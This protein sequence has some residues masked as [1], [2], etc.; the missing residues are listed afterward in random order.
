MATILTIANISPVQKT[1]LYGVGLAQEQMET[2]A[3]GLAVGKQLADWSAT[4]RDL[5]HVH[6]MGMLELVIATV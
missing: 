5:E 2:A 4:T 3:Q 6:Y 1:M